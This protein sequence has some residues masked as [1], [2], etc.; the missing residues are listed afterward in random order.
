MAGE[1]AM[2][3][4]PLDALPPAVDQAHLRE[5][6]P[7]RLAEILLDDRRD[8]PWREG[9]Q[10]ER[11]LDGQDDGSVIV[12]I[13]SVM[14]GSCRAHSGRGHGRHGERHESRL[15]TLRSRHNAGHDFGRSRAWGPGFRSSKR[16]AAR[17][18]STRLAACSREDALAFGTWARAVHGLENV[19]R[20]QWRNVWPRIREFRFQEQPTIRA[21]TDL[22]W[23]AAEWSTEATGADGIAFKRPGRGTF[24]LARQD[25]RWRCVH[26]HFSLLPTQSESAHGRLAGGR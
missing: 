1:Q 17:G 6:S 22:A 3:D 26:S 5:A 9:V 7:G 2:D 20:E 11:V 12:R 8:V 24:V 14:P 16:R 18:T 10:V 15:T 21:G 4:R 23:I 25:G 19:E 13:S